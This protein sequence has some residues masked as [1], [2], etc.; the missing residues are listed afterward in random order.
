M[1]G[2][3]TEIATIKWCNT[4]HVLRNVFV[5]HGWLIIIIEYQKARCRTNLSFYVVRV[6]PIS[7]SRLLFQYLAFVWPFADALSY[8]LNQEG[9]PREDNTSFIFTTRNGTPLASEHM[10]AALKEQSAKVF[11]KPLTIALY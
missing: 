8:Q 9:A 2:Q 4:R 10:T 6:P 1:P 3:A 7:V 5:S 11:S